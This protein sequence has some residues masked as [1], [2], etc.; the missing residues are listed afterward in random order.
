MSRVAR[1]LTRFIPHPRHRQPTSGRGYFLSCE[2]QA[3]SVM[4]APQAWHSNLRRS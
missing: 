1:Q 2:M 4:V 3:H